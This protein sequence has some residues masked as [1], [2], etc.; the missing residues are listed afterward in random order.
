MENEVKFINP[1]KK[2]LA[3]LHWVLHKYHILR[4]QNHGLKN[5]LAL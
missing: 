4:T 1:E 2:P 3:L 5:V